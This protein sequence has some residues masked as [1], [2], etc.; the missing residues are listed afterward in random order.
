MSN[1]LKAFACFAAGLAC[2]WLSAW[3]AYILPTFHWA[4][5]PV[6]VTSIFCQTPFYHAG[7]MYLYPKK[8]PQ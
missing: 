3:I 7:V 2:L 1:K 5:W 6:C 4:V 8:K